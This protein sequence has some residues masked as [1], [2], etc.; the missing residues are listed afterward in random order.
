MSSDQSCLTE[1]VPRHRPRRRRWARRGEGHARVGREQDTGGGDPVLVGPLRVARPATLLA[2][3]PA[4][5]R[6]RHQV[7]ERSSR[8]RCASRALTAT[9]R[10]RSRW[11]S[12]ARDCPRAEACTTTS[13]RSGR[14]GTWDGEAKFSGTTSKFSMT[15]P[16]AAVAPIAGQAA[17]RAASPTKS[18]RPRREADLHPCTA[19]PPAHRLV[20]GGHRRREAGRGAV[21]DARALHLSVLRARA[22][23]VARDQEALRG[24]RSRSCTSTSTRTSRRPSESPTVTAWSLPSEPWLFTIDG[25]GTIVSRLDTAFGTKEMKL[26]LDQLV[27]VSGAS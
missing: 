22:R 23:R 4:R 14:P 27:S 17:P 24:R 7:R 21:R 6:P 13:P 3:A 5:E 11:C 16:A 20:V 26:A 18:R 10:A 12:I 9:G 19:V 1:S 25:A 2:R 8:S 15:L